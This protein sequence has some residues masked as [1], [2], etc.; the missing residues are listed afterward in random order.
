MWEQFKYKP[1]QTRPDNVSH[2]QNVWGLQATAFRYTWN[3]RGH[4]LQLGNSVSSICRKLK[5]PI[6]KGTSSYTLTFHHLIIRDRE[7]N[8]YK[9][10]PRGWCLYEETDCEPDRGYYDAAHLST[11]DI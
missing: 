1:I 5:A 8:I 2:K 3:T 10:L 4:L 7:E 9:H 11:S 6:L